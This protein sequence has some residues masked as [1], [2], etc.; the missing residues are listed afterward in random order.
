MADQT[1]YVNT[2]STAGGDGTTNATAGTNRAFVTFKAFVTDANANKSAGDKWTCECTGTGDD[3]TGISTLT[4]PTNSTGVILVKAAAGDV[5]AGVF[6]TGKY[7]M[8]N[9]DASPSLTITTDYVQFLNLQM[10]AVG[11]GNYGG[12]LVIPGGVQVGWQFERCLFVSSYV[13]S[14][15]SAHVTL[16]DTHYVDA[17]FHECVF[18]AHTKTTGDVLLKCT[19][20]SATKIVNCTFAHSDRALVADANVRCTNVIVY[21]CAAVADAAAIAATSGNNAT[22]LAS[23]P[24]NFGGTSA[25]LAFANAAAFDFHLTAGATSAIDA[26]TDGSG[27]FTAIESWNDVDNAARA[28]TWDIGADEYP[29]PVFSPT[30]GLVRVAGGRP[31]LGGAPTAVLG[32][33]LLTLGVG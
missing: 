32:S 18:Y 3:T 28:G 5:H 19:S 8:T 4:A 26:G 29:G 16:V 20:S 6:T 22:D 1:R 30:V 33:R 23:A 7:Y 15:S 14:G 27:I 31:S 2:A 10:R 21:D 25:T 24:T 12:G 11:A 13:G 17:N 9:T